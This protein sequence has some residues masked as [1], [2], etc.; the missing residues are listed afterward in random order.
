[1][2]KVHCP[3]AIKK[4]S[5]GSANAHR[6][7]RPDKSV[8]NIC[9]VCGTRI[10]TNDNVS[11]V[12]PCCLSEDGTGV[13]ER[14]VNAT[15]QQKSVIHLKYRIEVHPH[16]VAVGVSPSSK[17][18]RGARINNCGVLPME[19]HVSLTKVE[20]CSLHRGI[21]SSN[22]CTRR[23]HDARFA[24]SCAGW[25]ETRREDACLG[26]YKTVEGIG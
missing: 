18:K 23:D 14:R 7:R 1:M 8:E 10:D 11:R 9:G 6:L 13:V 17:R 24:A 5:T 21:V 16:N 26:Y 2:R 4:I 20:T 12:Y 25:V 22:D 3:E 19:Q 15:A